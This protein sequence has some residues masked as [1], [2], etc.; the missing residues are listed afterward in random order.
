MSA[1]SGCIELVKDLLNDVG[2]VSVR[3]MFGGAGVYVDGLMIGLIADDV[4]YL[5]ADDKTKPDFESEGLGPFTYTGKS[6]PVEMS[7]WRA[8]E[9][10]LDSPDEMVDWARN[11]LAAAKRAAAAKKPCNK[12]RTTKTGKTASRKKS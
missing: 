11:A 8:P 12:T 10:L 9:R 5:K 2:V 7:Y 3:R 6:K 1:S 4:L